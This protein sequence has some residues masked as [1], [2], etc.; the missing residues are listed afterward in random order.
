MFETQPSDTDIAE[1]R[2]KR[3]DLTGCLVRVAAPDE[4]LVCQRKVL[5]EMRPPERAL[6]LA[7]AKR[8][9][10]LMDRSG[11]WRAMLCRRGVQPTWA[12]LDGHPVVIYQG[13]D[14]MQRRALIWRRPDGA[15]AEVGVA[16]DVDL[17]PEDCA[18]E[19]EAGS[20]MGLF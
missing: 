5:V 1:G 20:Q 7:A 6:G 10:D 2:R 3:G 8:W 16:Q 17:Q 14:G 13:K 9:N 15:I 4:V 19:H 18:R 11:G 12:S